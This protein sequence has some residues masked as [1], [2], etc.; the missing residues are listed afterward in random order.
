MIRPPPRSTR[1]DTLFP[2]TT[3]FRPLGRNDLVA[4]MVGSRAFDDGL[5]H[6]RWRRGGGAWLASAR[7]AAGWQRRG[8]DAVRAVRAGGIAPVSEQLLSIPLL[9]VL[10]RDQKSVV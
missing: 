2:Y 8:I 7:I 1:T 5:F 4:P 3:L 6:H 9:S 10:G